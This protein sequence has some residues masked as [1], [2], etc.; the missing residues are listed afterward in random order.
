MNLWKYL[1][2]KDNNALQLDISSSIQPIQNNQAFNNMLF[3]KIANNNI[4]ENNA[5]QAGFNKLKNN[6][7]LFDKIYQATPDSNSITT[8]ENGETVLNSTIGNPQINPGFFSDAAR[9]FNENYNNGFQLNNWK[10]D[11]NKGI[12]TRIGEAM[13]SVGRFI[14]SPLGRSAIV[15]GL[16]GLTGGNPLEMLTYGAQTGVLNQQ[17][18]MKDNL[19]RTNLNNQG[20]DTS[21]ING[22]IGDDTFKQ[23]LNARQLQDN[24][25]YRKMYYDTMKQ[26]HEDSVNLAREKFDYQRQRDNKE[27]YFKTR[28]LDIQ[29]EKAKKDGIN[30]QAETSLRKDFIGTKEITNYNV[31]KNKYDDIQAIKEIMK[32]GGTLNPYDQALIINFN[33]VLDPNS[34]VRESEFD[35]TAAGQSLAAKYRGAMDK[36]QKGGSGLT[37][38]ERDAVFKAM[39]AMTKKAE[40]KARRKV[41]EYYRLANEYGMN[42]QNILMDYLDLYDSQSGGSGGSGKTTKIGNFMVTEID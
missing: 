7:N 24:A 42:P 20:I 1:K 26:N 16:V 11:S 12:G 34:V 33:K 8:N 15:G 38:E 31:I 30:P 3:D 28:G 21:N 41:Q 18:R 36:I 5:L 23:L 6:I 25:E 22:Y 2:P 19:Y 13:G 4:K 9:G 27:D 37:K 35:R 14:Q 40:E 17:N 29:E 32:K 10:A 39:E